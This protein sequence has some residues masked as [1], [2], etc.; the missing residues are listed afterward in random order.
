MSILITGGAGFIGSSLADKLLEQ[1]EKIVVIDNFDDSYDKEKY[2]LPHLKNKNYKLYRADIC[3]KESLKNI[4]QKEKFDKII[5]LAAVTNVRESFSEAEKYIKVNI[6][7]TM[8]I[9]ELMKENNIKKMVFASSSSVYGDFGKG[10]LSENNQNCN[11]ISVYG[12]TKLVCEKILYSYSINY[13]INIVILRFFTVYG[14]KQRPDLAI[15]KFYTLI[16]NGEQIP[17]YGDGNSLRDY[18]Y[19][20]DVVESIC[21]AMNYDKTPYEIINLGSGSMVLL[22]DVIKVLTHTMGKNEQRRYLPMPQGDVNTTLADISKARKLL[23][24]EPKITFEEGI[25]KFVK[26]AD[27]QI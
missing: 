20:D 24:Y 3:D 6:Y 19:I 15:R 8:N 7:G 17:V 4:F 16:K 11:P 23:N 13:A 14:P 1:G 2:V 22:N 10:K 27:E 25:K 12:L 9:M 21:A 18:V 26:W 5:H